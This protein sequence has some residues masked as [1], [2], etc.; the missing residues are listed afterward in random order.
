M[1]TVT[2]A[3]A[4]GTGAATT[5]TTTGTTGKATGIGADFNTFLSLLTTQLKNQDP[6]KAMD[7][8]EMTNQLVQFASV[9]QQIGVNTN[10]QKLIGLQQASQLT[11]A[12]PLMGKQVEVE[13]D[14]LSLQDSK[15]LLRLP[16]AGTASL[17]RVTVLDAG[18]RT[19]KQE[20][21]PLGTAA[22]EWKWDGRNTLG[23]QQPDGAYRIA[24]AG[25]DTNGAPQAVTATVLARA[26]AAERSS[27]G[28]LKLVLGGLS[29]GFDAVRSLGQ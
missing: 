14:R 18:G 8:Q 4:A 21:V 27:A 29:V 5:T 17:A 16:P 7:T 3:T 15:A 11:A 12:A 20:D 6:T 13:S 1:T 24:V 26:T 28:D 19:L 25:R 10:L 23:Q 2:T 9:E 22:K